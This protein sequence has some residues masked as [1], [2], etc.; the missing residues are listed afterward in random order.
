[1]TSLSATL[2]QHV[3][4]AG[5][6]ASAPPQQR[7]VDGWLVRLCP[8]KA[9]RARCIN[10][11]A[12]G[13]QPIAAKLA[14]CEAAYAQAG[15]PLLFRI[16][17]FAQPAGLET[18]LDYLGLRPF[19]DTRVMVRQ[20]L[21]GFDA[22]VL[23]ERT[24]LRD[25]PMEAFTQR[26]GVWRGSPLAHRQ[27]HAERL[28]NAPVPFHAF[29]LVVDG[30]PVACGQFALEDDLVGL[31]DIFTHE[32][33]RGHGHARRLCGLLMARAHLLGAAHAYLQVD[34]ANGPALAVYRRLGFVDGYGYHYR[35]RDPAV[36]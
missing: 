8:G 28:R 1:V 13:R 34:A 15:L 32:S 27:S 10:A 36:T 16:T 14:R 31:Y 29:E 12:A 30:T 21:A 11:V 20:H 5:L 7:W 33:A 3:E 18:H 9:R 24:E 22:P 26:V 2:L 23:P 6:N 35:A 4:D 17:P 19:D 25:L